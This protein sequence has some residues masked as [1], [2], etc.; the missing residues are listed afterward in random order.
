MMN[1]PI[2]DKQRLDFLQRLMR[3][4]EKCVG[5]NGLVQIVPVNSSLEIGKSRSCLLRRDRFGHGDFDASTRSAK[6]V[7]QAID[8]AIRHAQKEACRG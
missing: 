2:T 8:K 6:T 5:F 3:R 4:S 1:V 7:R